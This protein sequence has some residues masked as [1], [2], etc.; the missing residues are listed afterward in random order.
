MEAE[1]VDVPL[2]GPLSKQKERELKQLRRKLKNKLSAKDSRR[3]Q[4]EYVQQLQQENARLRSQLATAKNA[5][6]PTNNNTTQVT[7][8]FEAVENVVT[9]YFNSK[10][11][12][13]SP[14]QSP[15][16]SA[17]SPS[18][19]QKACAVMMLV[20]ALSTSRPMM[21]CT[22]A[23]ASS[24]VLSPPTGAAAPS[25]ACNPLLQVEGSNIKWNLDDPA[26]NMDL[27]PPASPYFGAET[28]DSMIDF[29]FLEFNGATAKLESETNMA[30]MP[31]ETLSSAP[32]G[33]G[34]GGDDI[35]W[36]TLAP[37]MFGDFSPHTTVPNVPVDS[38]STLEDPLSF[39]SSSSSSSSSW[40]HRFTSLQ[41]ASVFDAM[42]KVGLFSQFNLNPNGLELWGM[43]K[44]SIKMGGS[45][46]FNN[47]AVL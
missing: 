28:A 39:I 17:A 38:P 5:P 46:C 10:N 30:M 15:R 2:S 11:N 36:S 13:A 27:K 45:S 6:Q 40:P 47:P 7:V 9:A 24:G 22:S 32:G 1:G 18:T 8:A 29:S 4:K 19:S 26:S 20:L 12:V 16:S 31:S 41:Q 35:D 21:K 3:R 23:S 33:G 34:G 37:S 44:P 43:V 25:V 14:P 42:Q